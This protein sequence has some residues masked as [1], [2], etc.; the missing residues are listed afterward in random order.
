M[1]TEGT[2]IAV[3]VD[4]A[5]AGDPGVAARLAGV[6][7]VDVFADQGGRVALRGEHVDE[8]ILCDLCAAVLPGAIRVERLYDAA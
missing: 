2:F 6:C 8:C 7:P 1:R 3:E 4:D 5:A